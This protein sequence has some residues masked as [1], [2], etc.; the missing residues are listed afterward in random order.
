M[1][2]KKTLI[3]SP[4]GV[5]MEGLTIMPANTRSTIALLILMIIM[6]TPMPV[7]GGAMNSSTPAHVGVSANLALTIS[8]SQP[9]DVIPVVAQF[10]DGSTPEAMID[11][12]RMSGLSSVIIRH[13]FHIIPMV[14]LY[15]RNDEITLLSKNM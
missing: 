1:S 6:V 13:A 12:I 14:S 7:W 10:P 15:I 9:E 11:A 3:L 8:S 4:E 5:A 2:E